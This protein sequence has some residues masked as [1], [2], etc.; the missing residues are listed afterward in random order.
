MADLQ[1]RFSE[2]A[3]AEPQLHA[4]SLPSFDANG[5]TGGIGGRGRFRSFGEL[6]DEV[7]L[8]DLVGR[9]GDPASVAAE[10]KRRFEAVQRDLLA[11]W[12]GSSASRRSVL[13]CAAVALEYSARVWHAFGPV[14][15]Q[16]RLHL[17]HRLEDALGAAEREIHAAELAVGLWV[18]VRALDD[19]LAIG[20]FG[21]EARL[22]S[23]LSTR[24]GI[25]L[26]ASELGLRPGDFDHRH[27]WDRQR[28]A[29]NELVSNVCLALQTCEPDAVL[30]SQQLALRR[31]A[32]ALGAI[33]TIGEP[34]MVLR[35]ARATSA[36]CERYDARLAR[37]ILEGGS[38]APAAARTLLEYR[39]PATLDAAVA[40]IADQGTVTEDAFDCVADAWETYRHVRHLGWD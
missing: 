4:F 30:R 29:L 20:A 14:A 3:S 37:A 5:R 15:G 8:G 10:A 13:R 9:R 40:L 17:L 11:L 7:A 21:N 38:N 19:L 22:R 26:V 6:P 16:R 36:V 33:W 18:I 35:A 1:A 31:L 39:E 28:E 27:A 24:A 25:A 12:K 34:T 2:W 32:R 23:A